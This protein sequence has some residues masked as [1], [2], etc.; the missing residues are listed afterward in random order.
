MDQDED[1]EYVNEDEGEEYED[2]EEE[3]ED[4][5][6]EYNSED[7]KRQRWAAAHK[8]KSLPARK[9]PVSKAAPS[10]MPTPV[11]LSVF[12]EPFS[13][14]ESVCKKSRP[15]SAQKPAKDQQQQQ[16]PNAMLGSLCAAPAPPA[17]SVASPTLLGATSAP[18]SA[19]ACSKSRRS[20]LSSALLEVWER[21]GLPHHPQ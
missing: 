18:T 17:T 8:V 13:P 4:E 12:S 9:I 16:Q 14:V 3:Y 19:H 20:L 6:E 21:R 11:T 5:E 1:G 10:V 7:E 2:E 15:S